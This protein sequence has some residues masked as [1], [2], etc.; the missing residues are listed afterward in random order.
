MFSNDIF[1]LLIFPLLFSF[2]TAIISTFIVIKNAGRLGIM[3]DPAKRAHPA[4]LHQQ[5]IPSGGGLAVFEAILLTAIVFLPIDSRLAGI[6]FGASFVVAIG[7]L[8]DRRS[9]NP[10]LRLGVQFLAAGAVVISGIGI[11]YATNPL[12]GLIHF[13]PVFFAAF[14]FVWIVGLMNAVNWSSGVD[15]Q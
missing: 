4:K 3:D 8:D 2:V 14:T 11:T 10:Y 7:F 15:G 9:L 6:L 12:G 13:D 1:G 5:P